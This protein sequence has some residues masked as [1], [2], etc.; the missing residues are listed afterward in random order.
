MTTRSG[1][2]WGIFTIIGVIIVASTAVTFFY[3]RAVMNAHQEVNRHHAAVAQLER[4]LS[5]VKDAETGQRGFIIT[6]DENYLASYRSALVQLPAQLRQI[7]SVPALRDS[8]ADLARITELANKKLDELNATINLRRSGGFD[9]AASVV[10]AGEGKRTMDDLR[11]V[12]EQL[13]DQ[14]ERIARDQTNA[15]DAMTRRRTAIF[16]LAS[17]VNLLFIYWAFQGIQAL[18]FARETARR[19]AEEQRAEAQ[20]QREYLSVTLASIGDCVIVTDSAGRITFMNK[21]AE[22]VTGWNLEDARKHPTSEVFKIVDENTRQSAEN[23][24]EKVMRD[25]VIVG[26]ANHTLLIRR[27]GTEVPIDDSGA[28][29]RDEQ[30]RLHGVVL[31]F[32]DFS[33]RRRAEHELREAKESAESANR[34]KDQFLAMLS[35]ELRTPLTPVLTTLSMWEASDETPPE[36]RPEVQMLRRSVE[37]EARIIDDLLDLTRIARGILSFTPEDA[38]VHDLLRSIVSLSQSDVRDKGLKLQMRLD[39]A[40]HYVHT[41]ASRLQQVFW[42]IL[43]NAL[44][45]TPAGGAITIT[46]RN[47]AQQR[48]AVYL[49]DDGI[50][51]TP[52]KL[53]RLFVPFDQTTPAGSDRYGGLGLGMSISKALV[54]LLHGELNAESE[55]PGKGAVFTVTFPTIDAPIARPDRPGETTPKAPDRH[56]RILLVE[57]HGDT[58]RTLARLLGKR[59]YEVET[60]DS[61]ASA[62]MKSEQ[63]GF[64]LLLCDLGLPDGTGFD[65]I[66]HMRKN[67]HTPA[68]A[69]T[70]FGSMQDVNRAKAAGFEAHLT[71]PVNFQKLE[72]TIWE[73]T[74]SS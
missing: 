46:T 43:R 51:I 58:A 68:L 13:R 32:R 37:L 41:D 29:I 16:A 39:A 31:V 52:E 23:P 55:G 30:G 40:R 56:L 22:Q 5:T 45:F 54:D 36:I 10:A 7:A 21:V 48:L 73:L 50:G 42:N 66:E 63:S 69:L 6:G 14:Q 38:D 57:D 67:S 11:A 19:E 8:S 24:V 60:A 74:S 3:G 44:K 2:P 17:A 62:I 15:A 26:L 12:V 9:A 33:E 53:S 61:V 47:D 71:K 1:A 27:D 4:L 25:G 70:G 34:A 64:D 28:P 72:A 35:H 65:V 49:E 18:L 59:G 20:R